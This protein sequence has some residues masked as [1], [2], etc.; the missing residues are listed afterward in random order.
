[1][2][3]IEVTGWAKGQGPDATVLPPA[4]VSPSRSVTAPSSSDPPDI[5]APA[6]PP[7]AAPFPLQLNHSKAS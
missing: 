3:E 1:M 2:E 4:P 6:I 5:I 7:A